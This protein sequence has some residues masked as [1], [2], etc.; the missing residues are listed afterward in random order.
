MGDGDVNPARSP[1]RVV[2]KHQPILSVTGDGGVGGL[3][4][5]RDTGGNE[6]VGLF[7]KT[8]HLLSTDVI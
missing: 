3:G 1:L 5:Q 8:L 2:N 7:V 4:G 6:V